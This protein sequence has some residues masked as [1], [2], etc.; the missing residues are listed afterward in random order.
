MTRSTRLSLM[1]LLGLVALVFIALLLAPV[2]ERGRPYSSY[3]A[4]LD[5]VRLARDLTSRLGWP[6]EAR[7]VPFSDTL[8]APAPVQVVVNAGVS[9]GE[10]HMLMRFVRAG[11]SLL[12]A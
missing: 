8:S 4:G 3:S 6:S 9:A 1:A 7:I 11:G 2:N 10:A 12:V 5:G